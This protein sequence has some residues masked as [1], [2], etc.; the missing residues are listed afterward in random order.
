M[1]KP[2]SSKKSGSA[3][4]QPPREPAIR[5]LHAAGQI[6]GRRERQEDSFA[7]TAFG[8]NLMI[9]VADGLGG[10]PRGDEASALA[11]EA[12]SQALKATFQRAERYPETPL[13]YAFARA[14]QAVRTLHE[15]PG[16]W[17]LNPATTLVGGVVSTDRRCAFLRNIGDS[18]AYHYA[19]G[20]LRLIFEPQGRGNI[21][22]SALGYGPSGD[23]E[24]A[25]L[26]ETVRLRV[27]HRLLL[28]SDGIEGLDPE[29]LKL[30]LTEAT[31]DLA[32]AAI[33]D[34]VAARG[35]PHQDNA[36]VVV[37]YVL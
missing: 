17:A 13:R 26:I 14:D 12:A 16:V 7:N 2:K 24:P 33:L 5:L 23:L 8:K 4:R 21:V 9:W 20:E 34:A 35:L 29:Q 19:E 3:R 27:G 6:I 15:Q 37:V 11:V 22:D 18:L 30:A 32:C 25:P 28:A 1:N 36:T 10:H 31:P